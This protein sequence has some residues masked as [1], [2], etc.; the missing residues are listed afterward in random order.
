M[1]GSPLKPRAG[2][3]LVVVVA[4][5]LMQ[6]VQSLLAL[7]MLPAFWRFYADPPYMYLFN[8]LSLGTGL[9]PQHVDH[10]GTSLQWLM[11]GVEHVT[12]LVSG[13]QKSLPSDV[14]LNP[15]KYLT[16]TGFVLG[17]LFAA[18]V[19]YFLWRVLL[20]VGTAP[21]VVAGILVLAAS[22]LT[23][24]WIVTATPEAL[25]ASCAV[26]I[27]GILMPSIIQRSSPL[28]WRA[29]VVVGVLFAIGVTAKIVML[30]LAVLFLFVVRIRG[31][32]VIVGSAV[33]A[34]ALILIPVYALFPRM[35]GWFT[36][37]ARSS[38]RYGGDSPTSMTDNVQAGL[39]TV[40]RDYALTWIV[41]GLF[42]VVLVVT[43]RYRSGPRD[44]F[45]RL[46][47]I[48][49]AV[50]VLATV[51]VSFKESTDRDFILL[52]GLT[53][54]LGALAIAWI[55]EL[56]PPAPA[57]RHAWLNAA[58]GICL[59]ALVI[60]AASA[61]YRSFSQ[62]Q[63]IKERSNQEV[64]ILEQASQHDGAVVHSFLAQNEFF[65]L[66]LGSEWA[67]HPYSQLIVDRFPRN[68]YYNI[69][70]STV[71]GT[72]SDGSI[73]TL[74][75]GDIRPLVEG[76]GLTF[77][78]PGDFSS[79]GG[80]DTPEEIVLIDGSVLTFDPSAVKTFGDRLSAIPVSG[81]TLRQ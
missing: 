69:F 42:A 36:N 67:H 48:G 2:A 35:F 38:G 41:L 49:V 31:L 23:V 32:L 9:T 29:L 54:T 12:Y 50:A 77:V 25:V 33:V 43:L 81:C 59:T 16:A 18:S 60:A 37:M 56:V 58:G 70:L 61:N 78:L 80:L 34:A 53:P 4:I 19:A 3:F 55:R 22:G 27:L 47:A 5:P 57:H 62:I 68:L 14:V 44:P 40:T 45:V 74:D 17:V 28:G 63:D 24:P 8:S 21:A 15:E 66:M 71:F 20:F 30:P 79:S 65:A 73:G 52:V 75:C 51:G 11:A 64:A 13:S 76:S 10:P 46:P 39:A 6:L 1:D 72:R 26:V 7:Y